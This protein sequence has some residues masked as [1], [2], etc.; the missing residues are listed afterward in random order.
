MTP[1]QYAL[2][3]QAESRVRAQEGRRLP[4]AEVLKRMAES[5]LSQ[6]TAKARARHQVLVH[7]MEGSEEAWYETERGV[8]PV[9]S[10][11]LEEALE[12]HE[13]LRMGAD[14]RLEEAALQTLACEKSKVLPVVEATNVTGDDLEL[15]C[16]A[17]RNICG[18]HTLELSTPAKRVPDEIHEDV[19]DRSGVD[20]RALQ[21]RPG[22]GTV[23]VESNLDHLCDSSEQRNDCPSATPTSISPPRRTAIPNATIR[24]VFARAGHRCECCGRKGGRLDVHHRDP[25]SEGGS[26]DPGCLELLCRACHTMNHEPDSKRKAH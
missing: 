2:Y 10:E 16:A 12:G 13:V 5:V 20:H 26:N 23:T 7:T 24:R 1:D 25:V 17:D 18:K 22:R 4:R 21:S 19:S 11:V 3:E 14:G 6:G 8:L 9:A 15:G